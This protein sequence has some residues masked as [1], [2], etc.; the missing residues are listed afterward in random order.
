MPKRRFL[1]LATVALLLTA[2]QAPASSP[3]P[4]EA[5]PAGPDDA[6]LMIQLTEAGAAVPALRELDVLELQAPVTAP[7]ALPIEYRG[8]MEE[9]VSWDGTGQG[10]AE[11]K[12][13]Y[14]Q[15]IYRVKE[16][17]APKTVTV[18]AGHYTLTVTPDASQEASPMLISAIPSEAG[19]ALSRELVDIAEAAALDSGDRSGLPET[20]LD[21]RTQ[22]KRL[23]D[24]ERALQFRRQAARFYPE[25]DE[26]GRAQAF[27]EYLGARS[28]VDFYY[29]KK[30]GQLDREGCYEELLP[31]KPTPGGHRSA[32]VFPYL[33]TYYMQTF[34]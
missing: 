34:K 12:N 23:A 18:P 2:C 30:R 27:Y 32:F 29:R 7:L 25:I 19:T 31:H 6:P 11:L 33:Y 20:C 21:L 15:L 26:M 10:V 14:G 1:A 17:E 13:R 28:A 22:L 24:L 4:T 16:G 5:T 9:Q 3:A 8:G